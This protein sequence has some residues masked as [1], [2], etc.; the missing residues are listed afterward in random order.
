MQTL[1]FKEFLNKQC[2]PLLYL[3]LQDEIAEFNEL[4]N[5]TAVK[6][7]KELSCMLETHTSFC[8]KT[9]IGNHGKSAQY[10]MGYI[11]LDNLCH[12][13]SASI[14]W[15]DLELCIHCLSNWHSTIIIMQSG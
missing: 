12:E 6:I 9:S 10:W 13:F 5:P 11:N 4:E 2:N 8:D 1:H 14:K 15:G 3:T 7:S